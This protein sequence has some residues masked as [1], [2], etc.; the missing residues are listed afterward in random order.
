[1]CVIKISDRVER[2]GRAEKVPEEIMA[3]NI[4]NLAQDINLQIQGAAIT[5]NRGNPK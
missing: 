5:P 1:M 3:E 4:L 2:I